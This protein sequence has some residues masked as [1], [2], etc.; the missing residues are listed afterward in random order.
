MPGQSYYL[1]AIEAVKIIVEKAS[2]VS[3]NWIPGHINILGND[4]TDEQAKQASL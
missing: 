4:H 3:I 2:K 1:R